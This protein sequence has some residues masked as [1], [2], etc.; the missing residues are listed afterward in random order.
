MA[1]IPATSVTFGDSGLDRAGHLRGDAARQADLW[2]DPSARVLPLWKNKP[3]VRGE[4]GNALGWLVPGHAGLDSALDPPVFLGL[5]DAGPRF[6]LDLSG[7]A[8][9]ATEAAPEDGFRD[10]SEQVHPD[11]PQGDRFMELRNCM[12]QLDARSAELAAVARG[13]LGWHDRHRFCANCGSRSDMAMA[14]W[15]RDC[16][17]CAAHHFPRTDPVAIMLITHGNSILLGRSPLW[18]EKMFSLLAGFIE[19][20]ETVE[21]AVR[22]EVFEEAGVRVGAV[23]YLVSQPWPF[24]AS[25]MLACRGEAVSTDITVDPVEIEEARWVSRE[26][27]IEV[28]EGIHPEIAPS[29]PGAIA[30]FVIERWLADRLDEPMA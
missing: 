2:A 13:I 8:P 26:E 20:G 22:R 15:Q 24:P 21:A 30:R 10:L 16:P 17:A 19:P 28:F 9:P 23:S 27:M 4:D 5:D 14:G 18:P 29:R 6:A 11:F 1:F 3:L 25:L 12:T 7:W